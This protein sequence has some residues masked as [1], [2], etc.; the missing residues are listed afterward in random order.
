MSFTI[1]YRWRCVFEAHPEKT[2]C[3]FLSLRHSLSHEVKVMYVNDDVC[4]HKVCFIS[5]IQ[6]T[7][8]PTGCLFLWHVQDLCKWW[9]LYIVQLLSLNKTSRNAACRW[10][11]LCL[12]I[13][14][15]FLLYSKNYFPPCKA[16]IRLSRGVFCL[17]CHSNWCHSVNLIINLSL[18]TPVIFTNGSNMVCMV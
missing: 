1:I 16:I 14:H 7:Y 4:T 15:I 8:K 6:A 3:F 12:H 13:P 11:Y 10:L 5:F 9:W 2:C 18:L 17:S